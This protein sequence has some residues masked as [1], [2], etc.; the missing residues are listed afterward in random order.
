[1]F[2][3]SVNYMGYYFCLLFLSKIGKG[4]AECWFKT[5]SVGVKL[6]MFRSFHH[7]SLKLAWSKN[8]GVLIDSIFIIY[9]VFLIIY[10]QYVDCF[11][12]DYAE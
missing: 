11:F 5:P 4:K 1:M 2:P 9:K 8:D 3:K 7:S 6:K 12:L 10:V